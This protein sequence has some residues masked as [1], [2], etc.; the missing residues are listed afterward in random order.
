MARLIVKPNSPDSREL[1]LKPGDN[2]I[3]RGFAN[4][5][6]IEDPSVSSSHCR[7][8]VSDGSITIKDLG[9]T[10]GTFVNR[11][12]V[13]EAMLQAGQTVHL[14]GVE[15]AFYSDAAAMAPAPPLPNTSTPASL[16]FAPSRPAYSLSR[17]V[18]AEPPLSELES[19]PPVIPPLP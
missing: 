6:K 8:T 13:Q 2:L 12:P 15:M 16:A 1:H 19:P 3:G 18:E 14:G 4:D 11:A 17:T 5:I 7:I 9:S 10:N